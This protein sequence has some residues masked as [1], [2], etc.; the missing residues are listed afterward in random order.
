MT[1]L[2]GTATG[3][4]RETGSGADPE[5]VLDCGRASELAERDGVVYAASRS[6]LYRSTDGGDAWVDLDVPEGDVW[7]V[8]PA[9]DGRL[10]AGSYPARLFVSAGGGGWEEFAS[11]QAVPERERWYCP[12]DPE[13]GRVRTVRTVPGRADR[14]V[15]GVEVGGLYVSD[16]RGES[17]TRQ[18]DPVDDDVHHVNVQGRDEYLVCCGKLDLD[19]EYSSAGLFRTTDGGGSWDRLDLGEHAYVRESLV[20]D[21]TTYVS[22]ARH[23][24]GD[25]AGD[26]GAGAAL[27]ESHDGGSTF[28]AVSYPGEPQEVVLSW[29]VDD[30]RVYGGT[31]TRVHDRGRLVRRHEGGWEDVGT[32]PGNVF[33]LVAV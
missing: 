6:G 3:V 29:A 27:F 18:G 14:L 8:H 5:R 20:H 28:E 25:W 1:L 22:G 31:G 10:L 23:T 15:V 13:R 9:A 11:L 2:V 33:S 12:G 7:S 19:G 21:G 30:G 24:P 16:D 32:V 17:W 4:Y 26:D